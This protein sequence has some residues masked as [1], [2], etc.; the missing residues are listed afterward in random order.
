MTDAV[1]TVQ[2]PGQPIDL[3]MVEIMAMEH[4]TSKESRLVKGLVLDHG[5]R[6][7]DMPKKVPNAYI[8][9]C[10]IGLEYEKSE[11]QAVSAYDPPMALAGT[12]G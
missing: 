11:V 4:R 10:N 9:T 12:Q 6:H 1:L 2:R 5:G 8:L 3:H 7:P